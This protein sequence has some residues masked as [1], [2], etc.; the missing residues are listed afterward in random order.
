MTTFIFFQ[1]MPPPH[2]LNISLQK[3][4]FFQNQKICFGIQ[5]FG[6]LS[7]C[8]YLLYMI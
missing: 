8:Y 1:N 2:P 7:E 4:N 6:E 3:N 5:E